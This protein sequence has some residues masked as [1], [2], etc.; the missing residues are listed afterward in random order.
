MRL[1][2]NPAFLIVSGL[3]V[4]ALL[5]MQRRDRIIAGFAWML[6]VVAYLNTS[7]AAVGAFMRAWQVPPAPECHQP[8][9][10]G[11]YVVLTGGI[12]IRARR[13]SEVEWLSQATYR[14]TFAA[15]AF[16]AQ[17][18]DSRLLISGGQPR[19]FVKEALA[20]RELVL[21]LGWPADR[22]STEDVS[23]D[24]YT[25]AIEV[26]AQLRRDR[27]V[28]PVILVTSASHMRRAVFA[29]RSMG[30]DVIPCSADVLDVERLP[31][32]LLPQP[33]ILQRAAEGWREV[34]GLLA[35]RLRVAMR[36]TAP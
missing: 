20:V 11:T 21:Q 15:I 7:G 6:F 27:V 35:Y 36:A 14:R 30:V 1:I 2:F 5:A 29:Y 18:P 10:G 8:H 9:P 24:T 13:P 25:S 34:A 16:A 22:L 33:P 32:S 28:M 3:L 31:L 26:A 12:S 4:L 23:V 17:S 19:G